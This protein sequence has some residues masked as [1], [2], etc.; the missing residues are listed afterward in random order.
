MKRKTNEL[1]YDI[2]YMRVSHG[3]TLL[4]NKTQTTTTTTDMIM[5]LKSANVEIIKNE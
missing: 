1:V 2:K 5:E 3:V 4:N